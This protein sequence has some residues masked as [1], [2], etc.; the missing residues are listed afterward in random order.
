MRGKED[1]TVLLYFE[2]VR[3][4]QLSALQSTFSPNLIVHLSQDGQQDP[5]SGAGG[6]GRSLGSAN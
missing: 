2:E 3:Y 4:L 5:D 6:P 1:F